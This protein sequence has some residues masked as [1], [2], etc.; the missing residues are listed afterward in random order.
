M[1]LRQQ[2]LIR[3]VSVVQISLPVAAWVDPSRRPAIQVPGPKWRWALGIVI[4]FFGLISYL[5]WG[6]KGSREA[7]RQP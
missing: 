3:V 6:V 4:N 1:T 7:F 5:V 2:G